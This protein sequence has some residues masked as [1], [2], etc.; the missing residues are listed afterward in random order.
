[1]SRFIRCKKSNVALE[2]YTNVHCVLK[3]FILLT[4]DDK[5]RKISSQFLMHIHP[6]SSETL[7]NDKTNTAEPFKQF[8]FMTLTLAAL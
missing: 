8:S 3:R 1:M 4:E 7:F 6:A 2:T 5:I